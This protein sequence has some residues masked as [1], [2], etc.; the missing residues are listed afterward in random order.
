MPFPFT[1]V[2]SPSEKL[3]ISP[4]GFL[5]INEPNRGLISCSVDKTIKIWHLKTFACIRSLYGHTDEIWCIKLLDNEHKF[6]SG[7]H[8]QTIKLWCLET[9]VCLRTFTG[10]QE[11]IN[12]L[13]VLPDFRIAS[14]SNRGIKIWDTRSGDCIMNLNKH[15]DWLSS[16]EKLPNDNLVSCSHDN[17]VRF[18]TLLF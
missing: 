3:L 11:G 14:G 2:K 18:V 6:I 16:M 1:H 10:H 7:S 8:D 13:Q 4:F 15:T 17:T 5:N 12:C 9:G